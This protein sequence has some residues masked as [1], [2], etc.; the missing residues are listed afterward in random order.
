MFFPIDEVLKVNYISPR[1]TRLIPIPCPHCGYVL[2]VNEN[3]TEF[4]CT[5]P[6][7]AGHMAAKMEDMFKQLEIPDLGYIKCLDIVKENRLKHHMEVF[8][9]NVDQMPKRHKLE[10]RQKFYNNIQAKRKMKLSEFIGL[11]KFD[12]LANKRATKIFDIY[13]SIA[14]F[15]KAYNYD[16]E[17]LSKKLKMNIKKTIPHIHRT[18]IEYE[19]LL[20]ITEQYFQIDSVSSNIVFV[21]ITGSVTSIKKED[22]TSYKSRNEFIS[23]LKELSKEYVQ[24]NISANMTKDCTCLL[25]DDNS[26]HRKYNDAVSLN[27][28]IITYKQFYDAILKLIA[29]EKAKRE[30]ESE[31]ESYEQ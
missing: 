11:F 14:E 31:E 25:R 5:N 10:I 22:G 13:N 8:T 28:P 1:V 15:Y 6:Q 3:L 23:Y 12:N 26:K 16:I 4:R 18:L 24:I 21:A 29:M 19:D 30:K 7:C 2:M 20:R 9:L 27:K 17:F